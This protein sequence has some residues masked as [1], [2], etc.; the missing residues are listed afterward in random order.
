MIGKSDSGRGRNNCNAVCRVT[1]EGRRR[2]SGA[3][4]VLSPNTLSVFIYL[5]SPSA[6]FLGSG[7]KKV[8]RKCFRT[9]RT[10]ILQPWSRRG[11]RTFQHSVSRTPAVKQLSNTKLLEIIRQDREDNISTAVVE[12][13]SDV[14][15]SQEHNGHPR[16]SLPHA[17]HIPRLPQSPLT[18]QGLGA[19]R[20]RHRAVKP[21]PSGTRSPFQLKLQKNPYAIALATPPRLCVLTGLRLPSYFHI[22]FGVATHPQ[23]GA[24]WHLPKLPTHAVS[25]PGDDEMPSLKPEESDPLP[26]EPDGAS[27]TLESS[28][29]TLS[30]T[31]FLACGQ[32]LAHVSGLTSPKYKRLMPYRW[33]QDPSVKIP[34]IVWRE[35]MDVFVLDILRRNLLQNLSYLASR[36]AAYIVPCSNY[37]GINN[38]DQVAAVLWLRKD[39]DVPTHDGWS[40]SEPNSFGIKETA[41]P[42][43]AMHD[44]R[45]RYVPCYNLAALLGLGYLDTL[46]VSRPGE[47]GDQFAVLKLKRNTVKVQL[48]MWKLLGYLIQDGKKI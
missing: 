15:D 41:P 17:T 39:A 34:D 31:H 30:S 36:P 35:D 40:T 20:I 29:R 6:I 18:D 10:S 47:Y 8:M 19:A 42:P 16:T 48:E 23:T 13:K 28:I 46:Q 22:P 12:A 11:L 4:E 32:V 1:L 24:P 44:Y 14:F 27:A 3:S 9:K 5:L 37:D 33:R 45:G 38:H 26:L 25:D 7:Q 2:F 43:Y 21:L